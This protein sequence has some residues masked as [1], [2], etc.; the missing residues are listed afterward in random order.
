MDEQKNKNQHSGHRERV[1]NSVLANGLESMLPHQILEYLLFFA[2]PYKDTNELAHT[3]MEKF[4]SLDKVLD[5]NAADL[6]NVKG[7]TKN[8]AL[9]INSLPEVFS[10]YQKSK[11]KPRQ[12]LNVE[13][14]IPYLRSLVENKRGECLYIICLDAKNSILHTEQLARGIDTIFLSAKDIIQT[15]MLHKSRSI[16]LCHNHPSDI[17]QPSEADIHCTAVLKQTLSL[18]GIKLLDHIIIGSDSSYS[19]FLKKSL[20]K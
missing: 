20:Y 11:R 18:L 7:M 5:A 8:A 19:F 15:A 6:F 9:L 10:A 4:G 2:I 14:V 13:N 16:I 17:E 3:L 12:I 1:K